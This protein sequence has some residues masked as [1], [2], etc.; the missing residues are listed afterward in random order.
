MK[1]PALSWAFGSFLLV[2]PLGAQTPVVTP[3]PSPTPYPYT[4]DQ[5]KTDLS[6]FIKEQMNKEHVK[7]LSIVLVEGGRIVWAE[8]FG[9]ADKDVPAKAET[10]YA[11]GG[12][13]RVFTAAEVMSLVERGKL[14]LDRPIEQVLPD[15][16]IQSRF[17]KTRPI[18]PR[19]LL[20]DH[21]GLPGF[22]LKGLWVEDPTDLAGFVEELKTDHLYDPPQSRYRY[23]YTDYDLLG[24][25]VEV[26]RRTSFP[27]AV[28]RDLFDQLGME[29]SAFEPPVPGVG[30]ARG[31]LPDGADLKALLRDVPAA[32]MVSSARDLG[33]FMAYL[34]GGPAHGPLKARTVRSFFTPQ[35]PGLPLD[36][37]H[38]MGLG[39][40]LNGFPV[41][42]ME[43]AWCD[44]TYP[45]YFASMTLLRPEGLG[46]AVLSNSMEAGKIADALSQR[47]LKLALQTKWSVKLDL[48][49]KKI[50]MPK[51]VEV[52]QGALQAFAGVYSALGQ[53][54]PITA[55][56]KCLG[57]EFQGH[58][59]DLLPVSQDT[60]IPHLMILIFPIDL[61]QYPLTFTKAGGREVALLGGFHFPIPLEKIQ[62]APIPAIWK[63]R[64]GDYLLENSDGQ[65]DFSRVRLTEREGFLTVDLKVSFRSLGIKDWEFQ[66]AVLPLSDQD[67]LVPG[68]FYGDG[69]TLHL[70]EDG[71]GVPRVY[72]SGYWFKKAWAG[73]EAHPTPYPTVR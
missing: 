49:Q 7:G 11:L 2:Y 29:D 4:D 47:V 72:Y 64:E 43:T 70:Q 13:S 65:I 52:P 28:K 61:P 59:L 34:L 37:G 54:A 45:G 62:P 18:T 31:H 73:R 9:E 67:L 39:W 23:S 68:L 44:G 17:K 71:N 21:S 55:K 25:L 36:F 48:A 66:V 69:G 56:D 1:H 27:E 24:R 10:R 26:Q 15:F 33:K 60:F 14:G 53:V 3:A 16:R 5:L 8:G 51:T 63:A 30:T 40:N 50:E 22:F 42:G 19:A 38:V 58:G 6:R 12:L 35:Y 46:V 20:A 32:G 41:E 57:I